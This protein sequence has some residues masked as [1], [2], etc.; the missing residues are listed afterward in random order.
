MGPT[1]A[2]RGGT[3][4]SWT[5]SE[6]G[7]A[8]INRLESEASRTRISSHLGRSSIPKPP[9]PAG[10]PPAP[11]SLAAPRRWLWRAAAACRCRC[12]RRRGGGSSSS[13]RGGRGRGGCRPGTRSRCRSGTRTSSSRRCSRRRWPT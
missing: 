5:H 1:Y 7:D 12:R 8:I 3:R 2:A 10:V 4:L 13:S 11:T 9:R 6:P